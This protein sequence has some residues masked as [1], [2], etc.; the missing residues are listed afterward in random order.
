MQ[1]GWRCPRR[2]ERS[3]ETGGKPIFFP[4]GCSEFAAG[5][6]RSAVPVMRTAA[7]SAL[8]E[9]LRPEL[10]PVAIQTEGSVQGEMAVP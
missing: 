9:L 8:C 2:S 6:S 1:K 4:P 3:K 5:A 7:A 10:G